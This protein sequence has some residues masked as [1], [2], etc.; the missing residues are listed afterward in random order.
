MDTNVGHIL[1]TLASSQPLAPAMHV[2]GRP[3]LTF[4]DL[5]EQIRY[6][7]ER[8]RGWGIGPGDVIAGVIPTRP[9]M[10]VA[11]AVVPASATFAPLSQALSV[12][13]YSELLVRLRPKAAIVPTDARHPLRVA[14]RLCGVAE[15]VTALDPSSPAGRFT[16]DVTRDDESLRLPATVGTDIA[17]VICT[18]GTTGRAKLVP[19]A[20]R[21]SVAFSNAFGDWS[22]MTADDVGCHLV[23]LHHG[24]GLNSALMVPLLR[25]SSI[26]CLPESDIEA[27]YRALDAYR[28]T[29]LT[30]VFTIHKEILRRAADYRDVVARSRFRFFKVGSGALDSSEIDQLERL[31]RTP[32]LSALIAQEVF[33]VTH[34]PLPPR[35]RKHGSVGLPVCNDVAILGDAGASCR[36]GDIGEIVVRGAMVFDGYLDDPEATAAA[37]VDGWC[38]TGDLGHFDDDGHLFLA[39]RVT[40]LIHRGGEKF[41]PVRIDRTIEAL[42]EVHAAAA[43]GV[44]HPTLG[45][46]VAA[47]VVKDV[48]A[49]IDEAQIIEH[50]RQCLGSK[51]VPRAV[52]FVDDLPRTDSGK[53]RRSEL[54]RLLGLD[55][56]VPSPPMHLPGPELSPIE[57]E[58]ATVWATVLG[59]KRVG[60]GDDFFLLGGDSL[61]GLQLLACVKAQFDVE[62]TLELL[63]RDAATVAGMARAIEEVRSRAAGREARPGDTGGDRIAARIPRRRE[64]GPVVLSDTQRR[65]W[66]LARL[67]PRSTA[68]NE[69]RAYRLTGEIDPN[70]LERSVRYLGERHDILRT[71]YTL[72][73]DKP[74]QLVQDESSIDVHTIDLAATPTEEQ[75]EALHRLLLA[76]T[77]KPFDHHSGPL[78]RC[79]LVRLAAHEHVFLRVWHHIVSDGWSSG[80]F[81]RELSVAYGAFVEGRE[82]TLASLPVQYADYALWQRERLQGALLDRQLAYWKR[83]LGGVATL[84]LPTDRVRPAVPSYQGATLTVEL[85]S[86]LTRGIKEVGRREGATLFMTLLA[87]YQVLLH[88]YS[89]DEDIAVGTPIAGRMHP[90]LE[91]LIGFFA[92]TLVLRSDLSGN[93]SFRQLLAGVRDTALA[94]YAHQ[95]LPFERL[96]EEL[97]PTRDLSRNPLFQASFNLQHVPG[98]SLVLDGVT[99]GHVPLDSQAAKFDL[100]LSVYESPAGLHASWN[101]ATDLFDAATITRMARHFQRLLET[102]VADPEQRIGQIPLLT[103][104]ERHQ[105]LVEWNDTAGDYPRDRCVHQLFEAQAARTPEAVAVVCQDRHLTYAELNARANQ[106]AHHLIVLGVGP[107]VLVGLCLDRSLEMVVGV[108]GILKAGAA[109]VPLDPSYPAARL[110]FMLTETSAPV[111]VT[112]QALLPHLPHYAGRR[113]CLDGDAP[114]IA[115]QPD[116]DPPCRTTAEGLA[117]VI[118]TSGSTGTPKGVVIPHRAVVNFLVSMARQPGLVPGDVLVAVTTLSFDIA[119]LELQLPLTL[120]ATVVIATRDCAMNGHALSALLQ[121]HRATALQATPA[122]WRVLLETGWRRTALSKALVGGEAMTRDLAEQLSAND[123]ELWNM[124]GPTETTVWSTCARI[125]DPSEVITIGKPIANTRVWIVDAHNSP[126]PIGVHGELL[127]GGDGVALGYWNR[128]ALTAERFVPS[129]FSAVPGERVYRTGDRARYLPD[130]RIEFLGRL[131]HQVKIRGFRI[132]LGEI[133]SVLDEHPA[134]RQAV[135][136]ARED[137]PGDTRLVAYVVPTGP[138]AVDIE[139][140]RIFLRER[141]PE[142]MRPAAYVV[143]EQLPLTPAGKLDRKGLMVP[144]Y[145]RG[146]SDSFVAPRDAF[147]EVI[148]EIWREVLRVERIGVHDNF[149]ELGGHSLLA[150]QVVARLSRLMQIEL[151]LRRMFEAPTI[152]ELAVDLVRLDRGSAE[153]TLERIL[154]EVEALA[155]EETA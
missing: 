43:F 17:Y 3:T 132:E 141:L 95:D 41:A 13:A 28:P 147:E 74:R 26:V 23:P 38:R 39:G 101:Y 24:H 83:Q 34:D 42:P 36:P 81:N 151:P 63:L 82:P 155:D 93:P 20:H 134:V 9:E 72:I 46:E 150:T 49:A 91:G 58:L 48:D 128:P 44:P 112:Q 37:F 40:D 62:L 29:W 118:Y 125:T 79:V 64:R 55:R 15:V 65:M 116:T 100:T 115:A 25:G 110:A 123:V 102:I 4:A 119:V 32:V 18:S 120:G 104:A 11:C 87:A 92:N 50:V 76:W 78:L 2:P 109:Y 8:L 31:F 103:K 47:A 12:E 114:S 73:D 56:P 86:A 122:T 131:D 67:D 144:Q 96:V 10:A 52:Y 85:S 51:G 70:A 137:S 148:A 106:L 88:R 27:F 90:D 19:I 113:L 149:F 35:V 153:T 145:G 143:L 126:C 94:A 80:I 154:R 142:Y 152:A 133:E 77:I 21:R 68:Y 30:A 108:L 139:M 14:A 98:A 127:V 107:G 140:L 97:T 22:Q 124:Y 129:P 7:R 60:A 59:L 105:L 138:A 6:V 69:S 5:G 130:G 75:E 136:L 53:I 89:G 146:A 84:E 71:I 1:E 54:P 61:R 135:V 45:E 33:L 99:V 57:A 121:H 66:F 111:L 117:Y 16:L